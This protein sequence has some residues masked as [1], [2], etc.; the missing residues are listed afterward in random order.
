[1]QKVKNGVFWDV[2]PCGSC[3]NRRSEEPGA[4]F[5]RVTRIGELGKHKLQLQP[6]YAAKKYLVFLRS[7]RR[8]LVA[9]CVVPSSHLLV[10]LMKEA[11]GSSLTSVLTRATRRNISGDSFLH[12]HSREN[13]KSYIHSIW[14]PHSGGYEWRMS[15]FWIWGRVGLVRTDVSEKRVASIFR[16]ERIGKL[17]TTL[18]VTSKPQIL[19]L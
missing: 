11:S 5:I 15:S 17:R 1:M 4:S 9:A 8:L 18:A 12:S 2:T 16:P 6:T 7:V 10:T 19:Q 13:L 14:L 3:K